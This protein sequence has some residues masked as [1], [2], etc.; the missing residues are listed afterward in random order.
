[1]SGAAT[2]V[3]A[4]EYYL[5]RIE[6]TRHL[7]AFI[8]VYSG[9][10]LTRAHKLDE[11]R[12]AASPMGK[13]HGVVVGLKDVICY[14][15]HAVSA[16]SAILEGF[17]ATYNATVVEKLLAEEAIIIGSLNCDEFAMGSSSENS[18]YGSVLNALDESR[19]PGG[20]SGVQL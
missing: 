10:A 9:E 4:I 11:Q 14:K 6:T 15:G 7:N 20:S 1:M 16:A 18:A 19:V 3:S 12:K 8:S 17:T 13:L 2:C 5:E